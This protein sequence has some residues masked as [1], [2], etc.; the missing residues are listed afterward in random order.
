MP[1]PFRVQTCRTASAIYSKKEVLER[2]LRHRQ[3]YPEVIDRRPITTVD[4][5]RVKHGQATWWGDL[6]H[7]ETRFVY[8]Q[9][10]PKHLLED[11]HARPQD[12]CVEDLARAACMA[13]H[14]ARIYARE[15][16]SLPLRLLAGVSGQL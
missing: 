8:H 14:A 5:L 12:L 16:S 4:G 7:V 13:R 6:N 2:S 3:V 1:V 10:L 15:R 9:L 11:A